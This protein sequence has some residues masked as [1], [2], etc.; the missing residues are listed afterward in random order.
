MTEMQSLLQVSGLC[1]GYSRGDVL[2]D[3]SFTLRKGEILCVV[4]ESGCGKST[5]LKALMG[6][7]DAVHITGGTVTL[8]GRELTALS[9]RERQRLCRDRMGMIFQN[10]GASFDPI[11]TYGA[12]FRDTLK[13]HGK[14]RKERFAADAAAAFDKLGLT[15]SG[16]ILASRPFELSGGMIQRAAMALALLLEQRILLSDEP[17]SAL[18]AAV[19]LQ[20]ARELKKLSREDG[21]AQIVVT[22]DLALA[23]FL[24]DGIAVLHGGRFVEYGDTETVLHAPGHPYTKKLLQ[25]VPRL[26]RGEGACP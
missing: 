15:D 8:E 3:V 14:F 23:R 19:R 20:A 6:A 25:A 2:R 17:T 1:A 22:H 16:R 13:G 10:P 7:D 11:R 21:I 12:Q 9:R 26:E 18:D 5:L 4:G 24:S